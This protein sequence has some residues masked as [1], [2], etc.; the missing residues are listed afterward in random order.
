MNKPILH[1][2]LDDTIAHYSQAYKEVIQSYL[3]Q[4]T[5][6]KNTWDKLIEDL[7][8]YLYYYDSADTKNYDKINLYEK[9]I[10]N[11]TSGLNQIL[12]K[13]KELENHLN[14]SSKID[15]NIYPDFTYPQSQ[16]NFFLNLKPIEE[17]KEYIEL[18]KGHFDIYF[19]TRPS[20]LNP[21]CYTEK[22]LWVEKHYGLDMC[23]KLI[24]CPN[25]AL[26][27]GDF[28]VDDI[29]WEDFEGIQI[30]YGTGEFTSWKIVYEK[31]INYDR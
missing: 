16:K 13:I 10:S 26:I 31:L 17:A 20:Y 24:I 8:I 14:F 19:L 7:K 1:I 21:L 29:L 27:K 18:L 12:I 9:E 22:R 30:Q 3:N 5:K 6:Q 23:N 25:K 11:Y 15:K 28:L 2:D 4:F